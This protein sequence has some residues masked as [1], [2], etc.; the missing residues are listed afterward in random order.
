LRQALFLQAFASLLMLSPLLVIDI[1]AFAGN[2]DGLFYTTILKLMS[3]HMARGDWLAHWLPEAN[4]GAGSP[5]MLFYSPLAYYISAIIGAPLAAIDPFAWKRL[6]LGMFAADWAGGTAAYLWLSRRASPRAALF[7]SLLFTVFP[8]KF[9]YIF[10]HLNLAQLWALVWLPPLMMAAEDMAAEKPKAT[11]WYALWV[12]LI[13][14]THPRTLIAFGA[15]PALYVLIFS[16][17]RKRAF[18]HLVA[19]HALAVCI[20]AYYLLPAALN[21][22]FVRA[23]LANAGR[24][25]YAENLSHKDLLLNFHYAAIAALVAGLLLRLPALRAAREGREA[26][27][28]IGAIVATA[29]L[30]LKLSQPLWDALPLLQMLQFPAARLH[31]V[32][33]IA[34]T[35]LAAIFFD[36]AAKAHSRLYSLASL[37]LPIA[38]MTVVTLHYIGGIYHDAAGLNWHYIEEM[39]RQNIILPQEY[40]LR[41]A[42]VMPSFVGEKAGVA[43][44]FLSLLFVAVRLCGCKAAAP[45]LGSQHEQKT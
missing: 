9:V 26:W 3:D 37:L 8:Y 21:L 38:V 22:E 41:E 4:N 35:A 40:Q 7:A 11:M 15:L 19:A 25:F 6:V 28:F 43:I 31:A 27:F 44:T 16:A 5:V 33:L 12:G 18:V 30:C 1:P 24:M 17:N 36:H 20:A 42:G 13:A 23:D 2:A 29:L 39:H 34:A 14:L 10:L 45:S 32:A